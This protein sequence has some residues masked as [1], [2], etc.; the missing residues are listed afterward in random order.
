[1][2]GA[3][4]SGPRRSVVSGKFALIAGIVLAVALLSVGAVAAARFVGS[5]PGPARTAA[6]TT[7]SPHGNPLAAAAA[8]SP[9]VVKQVPLVHGPR[10]PAASAA[11]RTTV[12]APSG[13]TTAAA[14][15]Y[16]SCTNPSFTTSSPTG[17]WS[18][19]DYYLYNNMWNVS[20]YS[21]TQTLYACS[22]SDWYVVANMNNSRGDGAVKTYPN[23]HRDFSEPAISS[24]HSVTSTFGTSG[25]G[26]GIYEYAYDIWLNGVATSGS[27]EVMIWTSNHGQVPLGSVQAHVTL[28]GQSYAVWRQGSYVAFVA[29][30]NVTSGSVD[31]LSVFNWIIGKG[32]IPASSTLGQVDYGVELVSTDSAPETF[33]ITDFSVTA[34]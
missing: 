34:S 16:G 9:V 6:T 11:R 32:W 26:A 1:M 3:G 31:L 24:L 2:G 14:P 12:P 28:G 7:A 23:V 19:G 30:S 15:R 29:D 4:M 18:T 10:T 27:T 33:A 21:V 17:G 5:R 13:G 8:V 20:G 25:G 22:Y